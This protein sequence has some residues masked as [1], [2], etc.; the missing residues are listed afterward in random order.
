[1]NEAISL[2]L[3]GDQLSGDIIR[4]QEL[5]LRQMIRKNVD[6][7]EVVDKAATPPIKGMKGDEI[8]LGLIT[9]TLIKSGAVLG[10]VNCIK[11]MITREKKIKITVK[12]RSG[13]T[14]EI[15]STNVDTAAV[16]KMLQEVL[17]A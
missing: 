6:D 14:V 3:E 1:M 10:V 13:K 17:A 16:D 12:A 7:A 4:E 9:I 15:N 8:T 5:N 2:I 11:A